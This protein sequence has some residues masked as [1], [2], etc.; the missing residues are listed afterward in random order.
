MRERMLVINPNATHAVTAA[1]DRAVDVFRLPGGP[2]IDCLTLID[3]P[4]AIE[5]QVDIDRVVLPLCRLAAAHADAAAMVIACYSDP[6]LAAVREVARCPVF[7][8]SECA[9]SLALTRGDRFGVLSISRASTKRHERHVRALGLHARC[10]ADL[11]TGV[12]VFDLAGRAADADD[13]AAAQDPAVS[14][15]ALARL[16]QVGTTL[17]DVHGADVVILGCAGMAGYR[18]ALERALEMPV[19]DPVAAAVSVALGAVL[20]RRDPMDAVARLHGNH[21]P[22]P[23]GLA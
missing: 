12:G 17:R 13:S 8:I 20:M 18:T 11:P 23:A 7:G 22:V 10:A 5:R 16:I 19:I 15:T 2:T 4:P 14:E 6:G 3:G 21:P 9:L 1:I